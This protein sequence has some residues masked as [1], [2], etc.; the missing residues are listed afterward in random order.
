MRPSRQIEAVAMGDVLDSSAARDAGAELAV[1]PTERASYAAISE[2]ATWIARGLIGLGVQPGEHVG[3]LLHNSVELVATLFGIVKAGAVAVPINTR[4]RGRELRHVVA[5]MDLVALLTTA[6]DPAAGAPAVPLVELL[7]QTLPGL[8]GRHADRL[9]LA[10]APR[11]RHAIA[12]GAGEQPGLLGA[13]GFDAIA[14][15]VPAEEVARRQARVRVRDLCIV[16][17]TSGTTASPRGCILT[18]E[19][20]VRPAIE[21]ARARFRM[22]AE[23]RL[24]DPLP[25][26]HLGG[27][28]PLLAATSVGAAFCGMRHF[29][30]AA[31]LEQLQRERCT[32]GYPVF[33]TIWLQVLDHERFDG[34]TISMREIHLVGVPERMREF[35]RRL[36]SAVVTSSY[37]TSEAAHA[38]WTTVDDPEERRLTT[39]GRVA[40]GTELKILDPE[41]GREL[42]PGTPGELVYRG[43]QQFEGYYADPEGTAAA[44]DPDGW[45]HSGDGGAIDA[46]GYVTYLGR[47]K[48]MLKVGGENV[49]AAEIESLLM[50]HPAVSIVQVV[51][52][53]DPKYT[54]VPAAFVELHEQTEATAAEL[55]EFCRGQIARFKLPRHVRFVRPGQWPMSA[56]KIQKAVLRERI[57]AELAQQAG[58]RAQT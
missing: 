27:L 37:G 24:W 55:I 34:A 1:F 32:L 36:E 45:L 26:F 15:G 5:A 42:P 8:D 18:H 48:D 7:R 41:S 28:T 2:R 16:L 9:S 54:E 19:A 11:L 43:I 33:E 30:S 10:E 14:A 21:L 38:T 20:F 12:L 17:P 50:R 35:Q 58:T 52:A 56:T 40:P 6:D 51:A 49:A 29:T 22:T 44:V 3:Y 46:D 25:L 31:A 23:D 57:R 4:F 39:V 47:I 13:A 53:P